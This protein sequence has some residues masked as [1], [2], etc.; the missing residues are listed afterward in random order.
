MSAASLGIP[1]KHLECLDTLQFLIRLQR[2]LGCLALSIHQ[3]I[4]TIC[5]I[6]ILLCHCREQSLAWHP[7]LDT[8]AWPGHKPQPALLSC[9]SHFLSPLIVQRV[10]IHLAFPQYPQLAGFWPCHLAR[11]VFLLEMLIPEWCSSRKCGTQYAGYIYQ[12]KG[13]LLA[14]P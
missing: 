12:A 4:T 3:L 10:I 1:D 11:Y 9:L 5:S 8:S 14:Q 7:Y 13:C 6:T 2:R